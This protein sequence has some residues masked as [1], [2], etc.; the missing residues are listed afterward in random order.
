MAALNS[1]FFIY[2]LELLK[3]IFIANLKQWERNAKTHS[4]YMRQLTSDY[5][6]LFL[7]GVCA[8]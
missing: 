6:S 8:N 3:T 1:L 4:S 2:V 7:A 5:S